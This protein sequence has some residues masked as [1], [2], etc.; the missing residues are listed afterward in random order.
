MA[1]ASAAKPFYSALLLAFVCSLL[2][3]GAAVKLRPLQEAN[4]LLDQKKNILYAAGL[5]REGKSVEELFASI[6]TRVVELASGRYVPAEEIDPA[7]Y[8]QLKAALREDG[9]HPLDSK[10]DIAG[11]RRLEKYS[12]VYLVKHGEQLEQI[13][14]PVRGKGLWSTMYAY[15]AVAGDL[16]TIRGVSFYEHGE[17]PGLGGEI[18][19][20]RWNEGWQGKRL[21]NPEGEMELKVIKGKVVASGDQAFYQIDG[22]SGATL[23]SKGVSNLLEFWFG[24]HGFKPYFRQLQK[25][26]NSNG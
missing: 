4:R 23:T 6:E 14:L 20:R 5:Y 18:E 15:V 25:R 10:V 9:G 24:D 1:E 17:T 21:Y 2:V 11:M 19:N 26:D 22:L 8:R 3:A 7:S 13:I 12:L 16:S